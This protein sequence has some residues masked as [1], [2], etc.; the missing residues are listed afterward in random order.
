MFFKDLEKEYSK[1]VGTKYAVSTNTGT[2][3][4]HCAIESLDLPSDSE[5]I[6]P[7]FTM[8]ASAWS[9]SYSRLKPV[10]VDCTDDL[11]IDT[12]KIRDKITS[13]TKA[14]MVT[15]VYGRVCDMTEIMKIADEY[16]LRVIEDACEAQGAFHKGKMV[17]SF[18][19]GC[20]SFYRNKIIHAEEGGIITTNDEK[21]ANVATDIKSMAFGEEHNYFHKRLGFN[22]RMTNSQAEM[23]LDSLRNVNDN[24]S[25]R[26]LV[27]SWY[28]KNLPDEIK[29]PPREVVWVYDVKHKN[30]NKIIEKLI[31]KN[32]PVRHGF[33]PMSSMPQYNLSY[34]HL[35]AHS[36][37]LEVFYL[38]VYPEYTEEYVKYICNEVNKCL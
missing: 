17:G 7:E 2:S 34:R 3:A 21:L 9:V 24:L 12:S 23:V 32:I 26:K 5:I 25:K 19:I 28:E 16:G 22:Y 6:V 29:M 11:L 4:L 27:E 13:K 35:N 14:I 8:V 18:D 1:Y 38:P 37:S 36:L 10:F 30:K 33:K 15:H 31:E 20:F